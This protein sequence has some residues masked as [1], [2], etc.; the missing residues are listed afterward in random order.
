MDPAQQRRLAVELFNR[1][2]TLM[3]LGHRDEV[4]D[5]EMLHAAHA[6]CYHWMQVGEPVHR[7]RGEWQV[8][9]VYTV[10]GHGEEALFHARK[11]LAICEANGIGD[12]DLAYAYEALARACA[13]SGDDDEARRWVERARDAAEQ[14]AEAEDR[15]LVLK[16]LETIPLG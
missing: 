6:S 13:V 2:W 14:V 4:Q 9:R 3:E 15:E 10:L 16:D 8:S 12:W 11:V 5:A 1:V 7:A